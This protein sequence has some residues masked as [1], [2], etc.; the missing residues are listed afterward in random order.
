MTEGFRPPPRRR[1]LKRLRLRRLL[2]RLPPLQRSVSSRLATGCTRRSGG[3]HRSIESADVARPGRAGCRSA[4][5]NGGRFGCFIRH[6]DRE[7]AAL[8]IAPLED[9]MS[10]RDAVAKALEGS[11]YEVVSAT[12]AEVVVAKKPQP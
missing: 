3:V 6:T 11:P 5:E 10:I 8:T 4:A 7:L 1:R 12:D 9:R 2:K